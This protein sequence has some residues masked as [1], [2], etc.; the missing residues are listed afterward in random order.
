MYVFDPN[1][2]VTKHHTCLLPRGASLWE[3]RMF[4]GVQMGFRY[5]SSAS[6]V[7]MVKQSGYTRIKR[8]LCARFKRVWRAKS[9]HEWTSFPLELPKTLG[10]CSGFVAH[11]SAG[12]PRNLL[13]LCRVRCLLPRGFR[14]ASLSLSGGDWLGFAPDEGTRG[15]LD[16]I[17]DW[18]WEFCPI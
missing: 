13:I 11:G 3:E 8:R 17:H 6:P 9:S 15:P 10:R 14:N 16:R 12:V 7:A 18:L 2:T 1:T 5:E 4:V